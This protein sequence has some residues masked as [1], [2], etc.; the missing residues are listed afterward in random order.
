MMPTWTALWNELNIYADAHAVTFVVAIF[1]VSL[2]VILMFRSGPSR[3]EV[4]KL[5]D[6]RLKFHESIH[7][8]R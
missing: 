3:D 4:R 8:Q 7:H 2:L 1:V 5:I 6:E